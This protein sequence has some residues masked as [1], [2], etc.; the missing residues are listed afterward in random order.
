MYIYT[1]VYSYMYISKKYIQTYIEYI[2][3]YIFL[4]F[5]QNKRSFA[6]G[7]VVQ[8]DSKG[9]DMVANIRCESSS[10]TLQLDGRYHR[11]LA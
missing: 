11:K 10:Q 8:L 7:L 6:S 9:K 1:H 2:L 4:E 5:H 3:L